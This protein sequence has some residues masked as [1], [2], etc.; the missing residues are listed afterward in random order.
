MKRV[1]L[2][3][4]AALSAP[5]SFAQD[6]AQ[7]EAAV[8]DT[9]VIQSARQKALSAGMLADTIEQTELIDFSDIV[10]TQSSVLSEAL[11]QTP[12]ARVN[13]ECSMCG[14][15]RLMLNGLG[16]QHTT[17]L[18]DGLP[19]HTLI[20]GFYGPD[21]LSM[22]GVERIEVARGAGASLT[23]PEAIGGTVNIVT[24]EPTK[25]GT[26]INAAGGENGYAQTDLVGTFVNDAGTARVLGA[27]QYDTRDQYDGDDN[28]V[29]ESP[30]V[31]NFNYSGRVSVDP[32]PMSTLTLRA[33]YTDSEIFGGPVI[34]DVTGSIGEALASFDEVESASLF[35]G[36]DVRN[37]YIG[38]PWETLEWIATKRKEVAGTYFHE[39]SD[40]LNMDAGI[41]WSSHEQDSFYEGFDY[42][43]DNEMLYLTGRVNWAPNDN[44]L[45]TFGFDR[46]DEDMRSD[47]DAASGDPAFV[48]DSFDYLTQALFAQDTWTPSDQLEVSVAVRIDDIEADFVDPNRPGV[49]IDETL[50]S[51]RLDMRYKHNDQWTSRFSA[52]Q[53]YRAPLSF[54]E[55]DHGIL[56]AGLGFQIDVDEL[57]RSISATYALSY[58]GDKL[59]WTAGAAWTEVDNLAALD[60]T[61]A[62]VP[63]L[64][65]RD[66][67]GAVYGVTFDLGYAV[68]NTLDLSFTAEMFDQDE[69][70]RSIFGV[71]PIEERI[72]LGADW[73]PGNWTMT[74]SYT[75]VG[76]RDL[77]DYG[78][79]GWNDAAL[80]IA[81]ATEGKAH[82]DFDARVEYAVNENLF[83]YGG[84]R[85]LL[86]HTQVNDEDTPL[87]YDADGGYDVAYIYGDLR[88]RELYAGLRL[89]F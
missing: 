81:K 88:G 74:T 31:E 38:K 78:Y 45:L 73:S 34:S 26:R 56:D 33:G 17:M 68:T 1:S 41:S 13:N 32:T 4:L 80:T 63:L 69:V 66:E 67:K 57:E 25:T 47:S 46:R 35:E 42:R 2:A 43:A 84:G 77:L 76:E 3:I 21:A 85:N 5:A 39:L 54:F 50:I 79:E 60:E 89:E 36:N 71:A 24:Q 29:A 9:I 87:F 55:T 19:A 11:A 61:D 86:D 64:T 37:R 14:V 7:E 18:I 51:P 59:T 72:I 53:G 28:G 48:S 52:G 16:G 15:K 62:G 27:F 75:W 22:A 49:E 70:M 30:Y 40:T 58:V 6:A 12:G 65:Q 10:S 82:A 8:Q 23:A 20:S 44:H 83:I